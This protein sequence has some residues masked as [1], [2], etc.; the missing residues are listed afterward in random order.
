MALARVDRRTFTELVATHGVSGAARALQVDKRS[1]DRRRR[2]AERLEG[3]QI[4]P[5]GRTHN[6]FVRKLDDHPAFLQHKIKDGYI[7]VGSDAHF[8][9]GNITTA[10]RA[11]VAFAERFQP[12]LIVM[13]GDVM[14][15]PAISR[16]SPSSWTDWENR[17]SVADE[18]MAAQERLEEV[19]KAAPNA[20]LAWTLGNHDGRF[21]SRI[22]TA[23]PEF[24][25]VN[26][27][28]LKDHFPHWRPAWAVNVNDFDLIIKHRIKGGIHAARN[29]TIV[30]GKS[31]FTGHLHSLKVVAHTDYGGTRYS[32]DTG[33]L[34][35]PY[36]DQFI[37][38][39]EG[40]PVDWR[41]GFIL[42]RYKNGELL[43]PEVIHVRA[44]GVVEFRGDTFTI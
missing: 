26:G 37:H 33:T 27:I 17:P 19:R 16:F 42:A 39:T 32:A 12:E 20:V 14:D 10:H 24:A 11:F 40:N 5:P 36:G 28:H 38:Y 23:A 29:N 3:V 43:W 44:P 34:A 13:N 21:E 6:G 15:F 2:R 35:E 7:L 4:V 30:A 41:S 1:V 18:I 25:K 9:P 22:A 31:T 8:W